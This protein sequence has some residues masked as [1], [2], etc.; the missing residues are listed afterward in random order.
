MFT[1]LFLNLRTKNTT[2][3]KPIACANSH[4][5]QHLSTQTF[6]APSPSGSGRS[7]PDRPRQRTPAAGQ[8]EE[9]GGQDQGPR[10]PQAD[11]SQKGSLLKGKGRKAKARVLHPQ[12]QTCPNFAKFAPF[13]ACLKKMQPHGHVLKKISLKSK[14]DPFSQINYPSP[15]TKLDK[16]QKGRLKNGKGSKAKARVPRRHRHAQISPN[17]PLFRLHSKKKRTLNFGSYKI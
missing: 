14:L 13:Q 4:Q 17:L 7:A 8:E 15:Q 11:K 1:N 6:V 3:A 5:A 9:E 16:R 12:T 10:S 2:L